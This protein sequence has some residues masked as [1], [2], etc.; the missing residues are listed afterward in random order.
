MTIGPG[1]YCNGITINAGASLTLNP[2][3]YYLDQGSLSVAGNGTISGTGVT[4]V[5]TSSTGTNWATATISSNAIVNL[6]AP[7]SGPTA[8]I[9]LFG[10]RRMTVDTPFKLTGGGLQIF[11]GVVYLPKASLSFTG[12][13]STGTGCTQV[14]ADMITFAG[15][16]NVLL[17]CAGFG[18]KTIGWATATLSE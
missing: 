9:V 16:A 11:G 8:G 1:V 17:N 12:G 18:T 2:G 10:D 3:I 5:F 7:N 15:N 4:L 6:T 13:L 14:V